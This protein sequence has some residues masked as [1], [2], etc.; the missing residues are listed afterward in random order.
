MSPDRCVR[1]A[2]DEVEWWR[3]LIAANIPP[4]ILAGQR[5]YSWRDR[6]KGF[7]SVASKNCSHGGG[8]FRV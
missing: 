8:K 5:A 4:G 7:V 1:L 6:N 3:D 2:G